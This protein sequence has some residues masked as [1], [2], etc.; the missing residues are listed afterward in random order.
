M[1][2]WHHKHNYILCRFDISQWLEIKDTT[3]CSTSA[4]YSDVLLKLDTNSKLTTQLYDKR[5]DFN[6]SFVNFPYLCR[7][8]P[9]SPAYGV[10]VYHSLFAMQEQSVFTSRQSIDKEVDVTRVS[11]VLLTGRFPQILWSLQRSYLP[12]Q[13]FFGPYVVWC[14]TNT[15]T[16]YVS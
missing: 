4:S 9:A 8:I 3:K 14:K 13:P 12:I 2:L 15:L 6:F 7:N 1:I 11:N 5:Y 16:I 10:C